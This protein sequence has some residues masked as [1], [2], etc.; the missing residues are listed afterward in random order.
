MESRGSCRGPVSIHY[1]YLADVLHLCHDRRFGVGG[2]SLDLEDVHTMTKLQGIKFGIAYLLVATY[3]CAQS[4]AAPVPADVIA[5][6]SKFPRTSELLRALDD[7]LETVVARVS[8]AVVQ[9]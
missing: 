6:K 9:I 2:Q 3:A 8:P 5:V 1:G 4:T 7:S